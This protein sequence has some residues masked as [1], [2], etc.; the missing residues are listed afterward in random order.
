MYSLLSGKVKYTM[1]FEGSLE[2]PRT[3]VGVVPAINC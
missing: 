2:I 3:G 1:A